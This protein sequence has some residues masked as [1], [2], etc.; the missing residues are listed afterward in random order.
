MGVFILL[1]IVLAI[2]WLGWNSSRQKFKN[3]AK[4]RK[5]LK[6][7]FS[8]LEKKEFN[9]ETKSSNK[10]F[11]EILKIFNDNG[12]KKGK[13]TEIQVYFPDNYKKPW[14]V[15]A[16]VKEGNIYLSGKIEYIVIFSILDS[17]LENI[18]EYKNFTL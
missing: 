9:T 18:K 16:Q 13:V 8:Y 6:S 1:S 7:K 2:F 12:F 15:K 5:F 4:K 11:N 17:A 3:E 10:K 14:E